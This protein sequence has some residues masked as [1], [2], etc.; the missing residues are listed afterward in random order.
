MM[1]RANILLSAWGLA[2]A[3]ALTACVG[4]TEPTSTF[5][6]IGILPPTATIAVGSTQQ[7]T[8]IMTPAD[9]VPGGLSAITWSSSAT[10]VA[11][12]SNSGLVTGVSA[13]VATINIAAGQYRAAASV[14]VLAP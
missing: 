1:K 10:S 4:T 12:V 5:K 2:L 6:G 8:A 3:L 11:T 9:L 14:R 7:F 13:G